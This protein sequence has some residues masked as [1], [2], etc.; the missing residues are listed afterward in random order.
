[1]AKKP[2]EKKT[3]KP[4]PSKS[5]TNT[6]AAKKTAEPAK[7]AVTAKGKKVI[8]KDKPQ[9]KEDIVPK[10]VA[11]KE[12]KESVEYK[13][14]TAGTLREPIVR[15]VPVNFSPDQVDNINNYFVDAKHKFERFAK[16]CGI[17]T[18]HYHA[19]NRMLSDQFLQGKLHSCSANTDILR[20]KRPSS[21]R[22]S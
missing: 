14:E 21:K 9:K 2:V 3:A 10:A 19:D 4:A 13:K 20:Y 22:R 16:N 8:S 15:Q 18:K 17:D 1:M 5:K 6:T 11:A 7:F 12:K